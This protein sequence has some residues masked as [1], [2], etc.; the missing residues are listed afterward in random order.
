MGKLSYDCYIDDKSFN[1]DSFWPVPI[2]KGG[3][4]TKKTHVEIVP[5]GWGKLKTPKNY[6]RR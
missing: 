4:K 6:K 5:K 1:V 3:D 2:E